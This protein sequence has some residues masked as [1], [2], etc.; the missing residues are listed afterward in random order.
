MET[1]RIYKLIPEYKIYIEN[2]GKVEKK[3]ERKETEEVN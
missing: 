2:K 1:L 3:K